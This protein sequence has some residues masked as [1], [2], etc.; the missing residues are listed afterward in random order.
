MLSTSEVLDRHLKSFA[1]LDVDSVVADYSS[2]A[3]LFVPSGPLKG[4]DAIKPLFAASLRSLQNRALRLRCSCAVLREITPIFSGPRKQ[5]IT[6]TNSPQTG[7]VHH[8]PCY[9]G[10]G[11]R[12][13]YFSTEKGSQGDRGRVS[14]C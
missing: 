6:G 9:W 12:L 2:D 5:P 7:R 3:V 14:R 10:A 13:P 4:P 1:D 8:V 11:Y